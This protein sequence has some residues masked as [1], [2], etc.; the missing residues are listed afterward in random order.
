MHFG[1]T[2]AAMVAIILKE[3]LNATTIK[4]SATIITM[5]ATTS[6]EQ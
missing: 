4:I 1:G 6:G 5:I 3:F 2:A